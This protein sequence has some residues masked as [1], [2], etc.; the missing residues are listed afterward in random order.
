[1]VRRG[2]FLFH[3]DG[4]SLVSM[5]KRP[6]LFVISFTALMLALAWL[7]SQS[8]APVTASM[9]PT[10][11]GD[12]LAPWPTVY[13]PAQADLGAQEYYQR[14]MVCHGD[15]GQGLTDEWRGAL[16]P[17]DQNCW[18]SGCHGGKVGAG[19]FEF[20]KFAPRLIGGGALARFETA[21]DLFDFL[22][23]AMPFQAPGSLSDAIYWQLTAYL[24]RAN[25][26]YAGSPVLSAATAAQVRLA[27]LPAPAPVRIPWWPF[28][29]GCLL[30]T[31]LL[32]VIY[33]ARR[34]S[35][36]T[37]LL[38]GFPNNRKDKVEMFQEYDIIRL[39]HALPA[40]GLSVGATGTILLIYEQP[41]LPRAYEIEFTDGN[42]NTLALLTLQEEEIE[43]A[44]I[45][46]E[47]SE[48]VNY[49]KDS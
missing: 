36:T 38:P 19:G 49:K 28:A 11:T 10:P 42:G 26:F 23:S 31:G 48:W 47:N 46:S 4:L 33:Y 45:K 5:V 6:A 37:M 20:P 25:G 44:E 15:R 32:A 14:C 13:P 12:R 9:H 30:L 1:M 39:K 7:A 22:K 18:Q 17:A 24:L 41:A 3:R 2:V 43:K 35:R 27:P 21:Q 29:L 8:A 40:R 34:E 16:D